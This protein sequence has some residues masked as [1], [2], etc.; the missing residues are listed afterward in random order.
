MDIIV[1]EKAKT[2]KDLEQEIFKLACQSAI[3]VTK[4]ILRKKDE[5]I[6]HKT[7]KEKYKSE[8]FRKTSIKTIYG[9]V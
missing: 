4:E 6:F 3:E 5:E 8:G 2:F 1:E 7:D 9:A